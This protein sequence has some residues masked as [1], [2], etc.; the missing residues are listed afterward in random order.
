MWPVSRIFISHSSANN[1]EAIALRD[2]MVGRGWDDIFLDLD[3]ERGLKAGERWQ[4]ALKHAAKRCEFV[5]FLIS[6]A[7]AASKWCL[8]EFLLAKSLNKRIFAA[9]VVPTSFAAMP[10]EM[11][12]EWQ[13]VDLTAGSRDH[14][15]TVRL[16]PGPETVE[17]AFAGDG[18]NRLR[19]GLL[20][21]GLE[22]KHF[23]W[24]PAHDPGRAPYRGLRP[25]EA[26]D[27]GIFFGR[28]APVIEA[29]DRLRGLREAAP[30]RLLVVLGASGAGKS[31]FLRAG[32]WRRLQRDDRCFLPLPVIR[33]ERAAISGETGL[34]NALTGAFEAAS[35]KVA[36]G[37]IRE[38][39]A[40]GAATLKPLLARLVEALRQRSWLSDGGDAIS[41]H[42][43][44][45]SPS[46][47]AR[48]CSS[49]RRRARRSRSWR[50]CVIC[51]RLT[52]PP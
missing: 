31:S 28:E 27:T 19:I 40:G 25:L 45:S 13:V 52:A 33:P 41:S 44:W 6:P 5:I 16:P 32:L 38:A 20:Q 14:S 8:A 18:L 30:P 43:R 37:D 35:L 47:R 49:P 3:P 4:E 42:R 1:A 50:C 24:P 22:A 11:T 39:I 34:L 29:I 21:A 15:F 23:Q 10:I 17:V 12:A 2:W 48:S 36:R 9:I 7:W 46:T 51:W 26:D